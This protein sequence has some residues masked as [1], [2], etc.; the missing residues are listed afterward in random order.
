[1][2]S[3]IDTLREYTEHVY[4]RVNSS[5]TGI[6]EQELSW[7]PCET[8]NSLD[9]TLRHMARISVVLLPQVVEGTTTGRW[10]DDYESRPHTLDELIR[11]LNEGRD[12]VHIGLRGMAAKALEEEIPLWG[13][14]HRRKEGLYMLIGE[15]AHHGGQVAYIRGAYS[16]THR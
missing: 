15:M 4:G 12:R 16:R 5:L 6:S 14:L 1:M 3:P 8:C 9:W 13:G 10:D 7:R 11:D 2:S